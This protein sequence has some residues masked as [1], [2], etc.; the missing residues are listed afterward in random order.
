MSKRIYLTTDSTGKS[1]LTNATTPSQAVASHARDII[2][3]RV[4][5]QSDLVKMIAAGA[6]VEEAGAAEAE[7]PA[8]APAPAAA[9]AAV[10]DMELETA[11]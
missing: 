3:V 11:Q 2:S 5:S 1:R 8:P 10:Q 6:Q 4:A 9:P 7:Q